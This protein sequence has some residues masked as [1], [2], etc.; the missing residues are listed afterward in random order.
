MIRKM[1]R[2]PQDIEI[3]VQGQDRVQLQQIDQE[4]PFLK[5]TGSILP[6]P[7]DKGLEV[8][9]LQRLVLEQAKKAMEII[10]SDNPI[11]INQLAAQAVDPL[12]L[13]YLLGSLMSVD[14]PREQAPIA[15]ESLSV[16]FARPAF[17][18]MSRLVRFP[19]MGPRPGWP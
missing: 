19:R 8:E 6:L 5:I 14:V 1:V 3:L 9:A 16:N 7:V 17:I 2:T 12:K 10:R 18:F 13:C 4:Q 11:D 15:W